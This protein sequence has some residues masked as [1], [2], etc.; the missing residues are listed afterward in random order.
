M[1]E[2]SRSIGTDSTASAA[3]FKGLIKA[4]SPSIVGFAASSGPNLKE[5]KADAIVG[6]VSAEFVVA[7]KAS[8]ADVADDTSEAAAVTATVALAL[9]SYYFVQ[10]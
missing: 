1:R 4:A 2:L 6:V 3:S 8:T 7:V 9:A 10:R 5:A